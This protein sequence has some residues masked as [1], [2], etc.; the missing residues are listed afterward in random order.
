MIQFRIPMLPEPKQGDRSCIV[1]GPGGRQFIHHY[2][3]SKV[4]KNADALYLFACQYRPS[5]PFKGPV[6]LSLTFRY[7]WR[8]KDS[9]KVRALNERPKDTKPDW[10]N[11]CKQVCDVLQRAGYFRDDV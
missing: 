8:K 2:T 6:W 7:P 4:K 3:P 1:R 9:R 11:L 10:D 5:T